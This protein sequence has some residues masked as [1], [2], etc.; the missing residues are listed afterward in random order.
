MKRTLFFVCVV[1]AV[2]LSG[3]ASAAQPKRIV[4]IAPSFTEILF[5]LGLGDSIVGTSNYCDFPAQAKTKEK[6]GDASTCLRARAAMLS[7]AL[8]FSWTASKRSWLSWT[9]Q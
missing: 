8:D 3:R 9:E 1:L 4:S 2:A 7:V 6:V 5:A